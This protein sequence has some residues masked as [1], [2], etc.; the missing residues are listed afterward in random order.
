VSYMNL[1]AVFNMTALAQYHHLIA[2]TTAGL[3]TT[4]TLYPLELVKMRM[5]VFKKEAGYGTTSSSIQSVLKK[6]GPAGLF[7][8]IS[9]ALVASS[10][11][12]GGYFYFY[13]LSKQRKLQ[14][15]AGTHTSRT[16]GGSTGAIETKEQKLGVK[17]HLLS[18]IE[19][20]V[21]LVFIFNPIFLIK[22]RLALQGAD[23]SKVKY[24]GGI[25]AF[26]TIVREE[27]IKGL[28]QGLLPALLL[29]SHG[30]VQFATYEYMKDILSVA[31]EAEATPIWV[32]K[33]LLDGPVQPLVLGGISK[34][35]AST[36]TYPYQV[37]K[38][39]LMQRGEKGVYKYKG[40]MDCI[41]QV[42]REGGVRGFF[43][44]LAPNLIKV[45]PGAALTFVTYEEM[46]K[47]LRSK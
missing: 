29:T 25:D 18:G 14:S 37:V 34:I 36:S 3:V 8:G 2:G 7:R 41:A 24:K 27:G 12:W 22:T 11:S 45:A 42:W 38:S 47:Y 44:G 13:E 35:I 43:R 15:M 31:K 46:L 6:E 40:T 5:Q 28:Y 32:K 26:R 39:R 19:A 33:N 17:D 30:A 21:M 20:G 16:M 10:G 23:P 1:T 4:S 9:P